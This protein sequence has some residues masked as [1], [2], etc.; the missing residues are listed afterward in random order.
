MTAIYIFRQLFIDYI[1]VDYKSMEPL[2]KWQ[3]IGDFVK[4][5][6]LVLAYQFIAKKMVRSY[7][8][9]EIFSLLLFYVIANYLVTYFNVEGVVI[10]HFI[11]SIVMLFIITFLVLRHYSNNH[12]LKNN[13]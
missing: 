12:S 5:I 2:F 9:T 4:L 3:L 6:S 10:A 11:R 8:F 7:V 1:F 13:V